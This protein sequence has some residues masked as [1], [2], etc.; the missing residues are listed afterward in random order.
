[1]SNNSYYK[2]MRLSSSVLRF[3]LSILIVFGM[4]RWSSA[5]AD[6][7]KAAEVNRFLNEHLHTQ[8]VP[9]AYII[10]F[11]RGK[12]TF[13][14]AYGT[15]GNNEPVTKDTVFAL[16]SLSK[17]FTALIIVQME[18]EGH[19]SFDQPI[20]DFTPFAESVATPTIEELVTHRSGF[21][22][23]FGNRNIADR[24]QS[25]EALLLA[26]LDSLAHIP[27]KEGSFEY[28]NT[29]Y[30]VLGALIECIDQTGFED[31]VQLRILSPLGMQSSF[32]RTPNGKSVNIATGHRFIGSHVMA[33]A[34][35]PGRTVTPQ[36][37]VY[38]SPHDLLAYLM[39]L[40][41]GDDRVFP[42]GG[43]TK[44]W[45]IADGANYG[46]GWFLS[47]GSDGQWLYH[48]G[49]NA[50]FKSEAGF[51]RDERTGFLILTNASNGYAI[52]DLIGVTE[53]VRNIMIDTPVRTPGQSWMNTAIALG[54]ACIAIAIISLNALRLRFLILGGGLHLSGKTLALDTLL[55]ALAFGCLVG[56]PHLLGVPLS[57]IRLFQ[58]DI[59]YLLSSIGALSLTAIALRII[60]YM[61]QPLRKQGDA[62]S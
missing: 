6:D 33:G 1:M 47:D 51:K 24:N 59:G 7:L 38:A 50:G 55:V 17:S 43:Q 40:A 53:G 26:A 31:S 36:S 13:E 4:C 58:P 14:K 60:T 21:S 8:K 57:G 54:L 23:Q 46:A 61:A 2:L 3:A 19:F 10:L 22:T 44:L 11:E 9:G 20:S 35:T 49:M 34:P 18:A 62:G 27:N 30:Q 16:G 39:A 29:N 28:S 12:V 25:G 32:T 48:G 42:N 52:G 56:L 45:E 5:R 37:A 15:R 41:S